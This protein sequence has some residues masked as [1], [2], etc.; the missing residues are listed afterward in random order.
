MP[1]DQFLQF[2]S[3]EDTITSFREGNFVIVLDSPLREN[4]GDL[5]IAASAM[6]PEKMAFMIRYTSGLICT[7]ILPSLA[8]ALDLPQMVHEGK[9]EDP[10]K[11]AYT[12]SIDA[13]HPSVTTGISAHD[14]ALTC[15]VLASASRE[16]CLS[17]NDET[18]APLFRR[19]GHIFPLRARSGLTRERSGHTEAAIELCQLANLPPVGVISELVEDGTEIEGKAERREPGMMRGKTCIDFGKQWGLKCCCIEDLVSWVEAKE[20]K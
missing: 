3:I 15:T 8:S 1:G 12:I 7:P 20:K 6:T 10:N 2:D 16:K 13:H 9:S 17:S 4:E 5:V 18:E 19:P 14:R 11:T